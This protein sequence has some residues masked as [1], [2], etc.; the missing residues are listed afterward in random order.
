M[1]IPAFGPR[2]N[3]SLL[4]SLRDGAALSSS[5]HV[6]VAP[7]LNV[8]FGP[9]GPVAQNIWAI[10]DIIDWNE[11]HMLFKTN[12]HIDVV[13]KNLLSATSGS[14]PAEY[15]GGME[16]IFITVGPVCRFFF[17]S[18]LFVPQREVLT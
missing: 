11:Q 17:T 3:T 16:A 4:A 2:P 5:G 14:K 7:T 8:Q 9:S 10:G 12:G 13:Y 6:R 18:L 15:K 1:Q